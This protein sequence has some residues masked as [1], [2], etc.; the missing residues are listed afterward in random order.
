MEKTIPFEVLLFLKDGI[1]HEIRELLRS[2]IKPDAN[3]LSQVE[4]SIRFLDEHQSVS[5]KNL[6]DLFNELKALS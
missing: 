4:N 2:N 1:K 5:T 6:W 3:F